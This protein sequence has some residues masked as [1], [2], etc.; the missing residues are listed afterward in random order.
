MP[1]RRV[2]SQR[3]FTATYTNSV[4]PTY[5]DMP[6]MVVLSRRQDSDYSAVSLYTGLMDTGGEDWTT[7]DLSDDGE[8]ASKR[9]PCSVRIFCLL[10]YRNLQ[11]IS[12]W[13]LIDQ[14]F[15]QLAFLEKTGKNAKVSSLERSCRAHL[16]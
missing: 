12:P 3:C 1:S 7:P 6:H 4:L 10:N 16:L 5:T 9:G 8:S 2:Y 14:N 11:R 15:S 13:C